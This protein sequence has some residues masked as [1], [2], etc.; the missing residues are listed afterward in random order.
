MNSRETEKPNVSGYSEKRRLRSVDF[1]A[2]LGPETTI[3]R[4][5]GGLVVVVAVSDCVIVSLPTASP[6]PSV[7]VAVPSVETAADLELVGA[8]LLLVLAW[9]L[10]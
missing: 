6:P 8:L 2:P 7:A 5:G 10:C 9:M 1:P 4:G 3:G